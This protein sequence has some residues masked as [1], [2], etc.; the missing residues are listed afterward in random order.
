MTDVVTE[1]ISPITYVQTGRVQELAFEAGMTVAQALRSLGVTLAKG[2][3]VR[4]NNRVI[5]DHDVSL[6]PGDQL[7][8]VGNVAGGI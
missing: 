4:L 2:Q 5:A 3:E 1:T 8:V 7:M 6:T